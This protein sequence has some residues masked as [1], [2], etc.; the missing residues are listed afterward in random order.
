MKIVKYYQLREEGKGY[1]K[2]VQKCV[3]TLGQRNAGESKSNPFQE[4]GYVGIY[5][6][7]EQRGVFPKTETC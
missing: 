3:T 2:G 5:A 6:T 4:R 7:D 1:N